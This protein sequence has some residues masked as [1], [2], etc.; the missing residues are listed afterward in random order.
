MP[1]SGGAAEGWRSA[2]RTGL[3]MSGRA[4]LTLA[5]GVVE[6]GREVIVQVEAG[7]DARA[8]L[9]A[10]GLEVVRP[11]LPSRNLW[12]VRA[13]GGD[14]DGLALAERLGGAPGVRLAEPDL[15]VPRKRASMP[16]PPDDP[17]YPGQWYLSR[18]GIER[19]WARSTG[20]PGV[21]IQVVDNGCETTHP[22]LAAHVLPGRDV[23]D[24]DDDPGVTET[25]PGA[26]HGTACAG[27]AAA[28][29]NNGLGIAGACPECR[30][31]CVRLLGADGEL[32]PIS[33]DV[34]AMRFALEH[35]DVAVVSNSWGFTVALQVPAALLMAIEDVSRLGRGGRGALVVFAAGNDNRQ[36]TPGE[37]YSIPE[38]LTVGA[39]NNF[40]ESAP[41]SNR[42]AGVDLTAPTGS[43]TLDLTGPAGDTLEDYTHLFGGTSS[44]CPVVAGVAGLLFS[45]KADVT[46]DEVRSLLVKTARP[47]LYATPDADGH[48]ALYGYGI[49]DPGAALEALLGPADAGVDGGTTEATTA[50]ALDAALGPSAGCGC[51]T[52]AALPFVLLLLPL[53]ASRRRRR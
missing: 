46:A 20:S 50:P 21:T 51:A 5:G 3:S 11:L 34:D 18:I 4:R 45:A 22:D 49:V 40:D 35:D 37:L 43:L 28:V 23:V 29:G 32:V 42:G 13:A 53:A 24:G 47:A 33:A 25:G 14:D 31:R 38:V 10:L 19:A 52:S 36:L 48:D 7:D 12:L 39:T 41:Y 8:R 9:E 30:V 17:R 6:V 16:V 15:Y 2:Q 1:P 27:V 26:N 44:A